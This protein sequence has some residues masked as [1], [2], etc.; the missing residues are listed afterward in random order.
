MRH[1]VTSTDT[2]F[3]G[4]PV[5][6]IA[7]ESDGT[8]SIID[9]EGLVVI[10]QSDNETQVAEAGTGSDPSARLAQTDQYD[11]ILSDKPESTVT[12]TLSYDSQVDGHSDRRNAFRRSDPDDGSRQILSLTFDETN[13][14]VPQTVAVTAVDDGVAEATHYSRITHSA[15][16]SD[17]RFTDAEVASV[18]VEILD[19][20]PGVLIRETGNST[21]VLEITNRFEIG[22]GQVTTKIDGTTFEAS[23]GRSFL[24]ELDENDSPFVA[25]DIDLGD[26][27]TH[28]HADIVDSKTLPHIT[29]E[30]TGD[31]RADYYKFTLTSTSRVVVDL[32]NGFELSDDRFWNPVLRMLKEDGSPYTDGAGVPYEN[33]HGI[34]P[35][36]DSGSDSYFDPFFDFDGG[37]KLPAGV[38]VVEVADEFGGIPDGVDY[39]L[40]FSIE[41]HP[42]ASFLFQPSPIFENEAEQTPAQNI[43]APTNFGTFYDPAVG[44]GDIDYNTPYVKVVGSGDDTHDTFAFE[45]TGA[46]LNPDAGTISGT[47]D[48]STYYTSLG[49]NLNQTGATTATNDVWSV[50]VDGTNYTYTSQAND[51]LASVAAGLE[52][53]INGDSSLL[54]T[55]AATRSGSTVNLADANGFRVSSVTQQVQIAGETE[56]TLSTTEN[57]DFTSATVTL[58][59]TVTTGQTWTLELDGAAF[60]YVV[61]SG[62][63]DLNSLATKLAAAVTDSN[64][65]VSA[66]QATISIARATPFTVSFEQSGVDPRGSA[67]IAGTP[68]QSTLAN[69][70]FTQADVTLGGSVRPYE[71]WAITLDS[72]AYSYETKPNDTKAIVAAALRQAIPAGYQPGGTG[73][74]VS[75]QNAAGFKVAYS[76]TPGTKGTATVNTS[77]PGTQTFDL[78]GSPQAGE[79]WIFNVDSATYSYSADTYTT[80]AAMIDQ[81]ATDVNNS[82]GYIGVKDGDQV[83]VVKIDNSVPLTLSHQVQ[84]PIDS[85]AG[86]A[87]QITF[88]GTAA[89]DAVYTINVS[90]KGSFTSSTAADRTATALA[91]ALASAVSAHA[92]LT[93]TANGGTVT[94]LED[95]GAAI[96]ATATVTPGSIAASSAQSA[97]SIEFTGTATAA[98]TWTLSVDSDDFTLP[99]ADRTSAELAQDFAAAINTDGTYEAYVD[100]ATVRV[101]SSNASIALTLSGDVTVSDRTISSA[102][103]GTA[104]F[105]QEVTLAAGTATLTLD[106][107]DFSATDTSGNAVATSLATQLNAGSSY[108]AH[109]NGNVLRVIRLNGNATTA[110]LASGATGTVATSQRFTRTASWPTESTWTVSV[111]GTNQTDSTNASSLATKISSIS[112]IQA[113]AQGSEIVILKAAGGTLNVTAA[114]APNNA[115]GSTAQSKLVTLGGVVA[116]DEVWSI[117]VAGVDHTVTVGASDALSNVVADFVAD[118]DD[119]TNFASASEGSV[120]AITR[121]D[122]AVGAIATNVTPPAT[123][124]TQVASGTP[125]AGW[126]QE[127]TLDGPVAVGDVW[128]WEFDLDGVETYTVP[129]GTTTLAQVA[130]GIAAQ[131]DA[132]AGYTASASGAVVTVAKTNQSALRVASVQQLRNSAA[133]LENAVVDTR[134]HYNAANVELKK[135]GNRALHGES[136][137]VTIHGRSYNYVVDNQTQRGQ[138]NK[139]VPLSTVAG[140]LL[141][142]IQADFPSAT[143][144]GS[145]IQ[146]T[147]LNGSTVEAKRGNG[148][149]RVCVRY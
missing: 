34:D 76:I 108:E 114:V 113:F 30:G 145:T 3:E 9:H 106:G 36:Q 26:W 121:L 21:D 40:H 107:S 137:T 141:T 38:Y 148:T 115:I 130:T 138:V 102:I 95:N 15:S 29:V 63:T 119:D 89:A 105:V 111:D 46:M 79:T 33:Y 120:I 116:P 24:K 27:S 20:N 100:G 25:Q 123:N 77:T 39:N 97:Q 59:G 18:D 82:T 98:E 1:T 134:D 16:S 87:Q 60:A 136:W 64:Y 65:T 44:A 129:S 11:V 5:K 110:S 61:E 73:D 57:V 52:A 35:S 48:S 23:F 6:S 13:W 146:L 55:Y 51:T 104:G 49:L 8:L 132:E 54:S 75:L 50:S 147:S 53:D 7:V 31:D 112:G 131:I 128:S 144:S 143:S 99:S 140:E 28:F 101:V 80:R 10:Q 117:N 85:T 133:T 67:T 74:V 19:N 83:V 43:D 32:D 122:N 12:V 41:G 126:S 118:F 78:A 37:I 68:D 125:V 109:V 103:A 42:T 4:L 47:K 88:S 2:N 66:N 135:T 58:S 69:V 45:V 94:I 142:K 127:I 90:G 81:L 17:S 92:D 14:N 124:G 91:S 149:I 70:T 86:F 84:S 71:T 22:R 72:V 139:G 62:V 56:R 93:A 96:T